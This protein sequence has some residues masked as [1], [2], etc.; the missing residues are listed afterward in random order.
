MAVTPPF[1]SP[2]PHFKLESKKLQNQ[3]ELSSRKRQLG[4]CISALLRKSRTL[5]RSQVRIHLQVRKPSSAVPIKAARV[6]V[7]V[8]EGSPIP[9]LCECWGHS[10]GVIVGGATFPPPPGSAGQS[11]EQVCPCSLAPAYVCVHLSLACP[12]LVFIFHFKAADG[13]KMKMSPLHFILCLWDC[14]F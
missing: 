7:K 2:A 4:E 14:V 13:E 8:L 1:Q 3:N 10:F 12:C 9:A 5:F 6:P 11:S